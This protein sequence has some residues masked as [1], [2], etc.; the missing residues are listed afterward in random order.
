MIRQFRRFIAENCLFDNDSRLLATISGGADSTVMLYLLVKCGFKVWVAHCNFQLRGADSDADEEFVRQLA[1]HYGMPF[2]SV[3]VNTTAYAQTNNI[4]IEMAARKLRYNWFSDL[5]MEH[6]LDRILTAHHLNDSIETVMLNMSRGTGI[7]G[8]TG[9]AARNGNIVRPMLFATRNQIEQFAAQNNISFRT[10]YTNLTD[11]YQRNFVRHNI[12]PLFKQIN[13]AFED[14]MFKN[15]KHISQAAHIYGWYV[16]NARQRLVKNIDGQSVI[17]ICEL[18]AE[19]F[20]EPVLY[21]FVSSFGFNSSQVEQIMR[22]IGQKSGCM[23]ESATHS[24]LVDRSSLII[25]TKHPDDFVDIIINKPIDIP[26]A[27]INMRIVPI[28]DFV[29]NKSRDVACIDIDKLQFPLTLRRWQHGDYFYPIGMTNAKKLS[30]FFIDNKID[31]LSKKA[32]M[33]IESAG[34]IVW[35]VGY[36]LDNRF[37]IDD[38]TNNVLIIKHKHPIKR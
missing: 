36:R 34:R 14:R 1:A 32:T 10:D 13:P 5:A 19:P 20:A 26:S 23:F 30:D 15:L 7:N 4:S 3:R 24:L 2:F 38:T 29:L 25:S 11:D 21:E 22:R 6:N 18:L 35:V 27:G 12:V 9:I 17:P 8:L 16:E 31:R 28:G 33:V 37:K